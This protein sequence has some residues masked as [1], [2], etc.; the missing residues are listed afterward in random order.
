MDAGDVHALEAL[1]ASV[2]PAALREGAAVLASHYGAHPACCA[3][4]EADGEIMGYALCA[5]AAFDDCPLSIHSHV[6][7]ALAQA[8]EGPGITAV[9]A[10]ADKQGGGNL[11]NQ[12]PPSPAERNCLYVHDVAVSPAC[13]G[14]GIGTRLLHHVESIAAELG[15]EALLL[16]A[17]CGARSFWELRGFAPVSEEEL[18]DA[19]TARLRQYPA[20][21]GEEACFMRRRRRD[22]RDPSAGAASSADA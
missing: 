9:A 20:D 3:V 5:V 13:Q 17:V 14:L 10:A 21:G 11:H 19:A 8:S 16:T 22:T 6:H 12:Q 15:S 2:Y 18:S 4:A 1:E 7:H